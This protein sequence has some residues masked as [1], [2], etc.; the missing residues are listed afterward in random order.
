MNEVNSS[1]NGRIYGLKAKPNNLLKVIRPSERSFGIYKVLY[2][3]YSHAEYLK[4]LRIL[5]F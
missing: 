2:Y 3:R 5:Y 4:E 1:T